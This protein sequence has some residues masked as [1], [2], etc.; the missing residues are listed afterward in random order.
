MK[1]KVSIILAFFCFISNWLNWIVID[2]PLVSLNINLLDLGMNI[3]IV[4]PLF[5]AI[6]FF[7]KFIKVVNQKMRGFIAFLL[8]VLDLFFIMQIYF[9]PLETFTN[10][11]IKKDS[12]LNG[13]VN[14]ELASFCSIG[15]GVLVHA[16]C[17]TLLFLLV[18]LNTEKYDS[19]QNRTQFRM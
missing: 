6:I 4:I 18:F 14:D 13:F 15:P 2:L 9:W 1:F 8:Y 17:S 16:L 19:L 3:L 11:S 10:F 7:P 12:L 5:Q